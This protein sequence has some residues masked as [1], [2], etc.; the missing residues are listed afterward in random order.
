MLL[1]KRLLLFIGLFIFIFSGDGKA[2]GKQ[3]P[4]IIAY[5][6][7]FRGDLLQIDSIDAERLSHINYAF[8]D[9][10][11]NRAWLHNEATDTL[12]FVRLNQLKKRNP[13]LKIIISIGGWSWSKNFSDAVLTDSSTA[14]FAKSGVDIV[15]K[16]DLDG[17][18]IDWEYPGMIGDG[19]V[20]RPEDREHYTLLFKDLRHFLDSL[21]LKTHKKYFVTTAV[22]GSPDYIAH[23]E[24]DKVQLYT[25]FINVMSYDYDESGDTLSAHHSNL[26]ASGNNNKGS[27]ADQSIRDLITAGVPPAKLVI[28]VAFYGKG[29]IMA[30][31]DNHG[32]NRKT[33]RTQRGGGFTYINDSLVNRNGFVRYW[34]A[35]AKAPYLFNPEKKIFITY[36]DQESVKAKCDYVKS[37]HLAGAM[38]WEYSSDEKEYLL[39]VIAK[40][41]DYRG[42]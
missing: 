37:N 17:V 12:N 34:D 13:D 1:I 7:G 40:C 27:S 35:Q 31:T 22:G 23:T 28:G 11:D 3:K 25:D 42:R 20:Y 24:M 21:A 9:V 6:G 18:D 4:V 30:G 19:N 36:D 2:Q 33:V 8:V 10:K 32:L 39:K 26:F 5:V 29:Q 41:F 15:A 14:N 16:Y 38:F